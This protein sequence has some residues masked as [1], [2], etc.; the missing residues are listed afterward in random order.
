[1][2][3]VCVAMLPSLVLHRSSVRPYQRGLYCSDTSLKYPYKKSTVSS[4]VL[5]SF[6]LTLPVVSVSLPRN[7]ECRPGRTLEVEM[8]RAKGLMYYRRL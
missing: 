2:S 5:T 6:G 1:M 8:A 7:E 4:A 3:Y